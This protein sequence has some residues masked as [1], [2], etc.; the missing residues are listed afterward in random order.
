MIGSRAIIL[1]LIGVCIAALIMFSSKQNKLRELT[2]LVQAQHQ[3]IEALSNKIISKNH[4]LSDV[5]QKQSQVAN[6]VESASGYKEILTSLGINTEEKLKS[7]AQDFEAVRQKLPALFDHTQN[8]RYMPS[9]TTYVQELFIN[10]ARVLQQLGKG[11]ITLFGMGRGEDFVDR[12]EMRRFLVSN[13]PQLPHGSKCLEVGEARYIGEMSR[14]SE[15]YVFNYDTKASLQGTVLYG[16][17]SGQDQGFPEAHFD[18]LLLNQVFEHVH[19][20]FTA[21]RNSFTM[22]KPGGLLVFT[23]P[24]VSNYHEVPGDYFRYTPMTVHKIAE[25][26]GFCLEY[27]RAVGNWLTSIMYISGYGVDD[28]SAEEFTHLWD[29]T[30]SFHAVMIQARMRKPIQGESCKIHLSL[31]ETKNAMKVG[32][33]GVKSVDIQ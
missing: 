9:T 14:C 1:V 24:F 19:D 32:P 5:S 25:T 15:R 2:E 21:I 16:D 17:L 13:N 4:Q 27:V 28:V 8:K 31:E 11:H 30:P 22:V 3:E 18:M 33:Q 26:G 12:A 29:D 20:P 23:A 6:Q 7:L 10:T